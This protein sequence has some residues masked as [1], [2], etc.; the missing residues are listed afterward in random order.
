MGD[1]ISIH[2]G[3]FLEEL[4]RGHWRY[5]RVHE[6]SLGECADGDVPSTDVNCGDSG[7]LLERLR[8]APQSAAGADLLMFNCGLHD[9]KVAAGQTHRQV[10]AD[11]YAANIDSIVSIGT[12]LARQLVWVS[13]TPVV[14][15]LH[16]A[17]CEQFA[18]YDADVSAYNALAAA[19][20][21]R[22]GIP[23]IDLGAFSRSLVP[24]AVADHVHFTEAGQSA[25]AVF[26]DRALS[27]I[28][29]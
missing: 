5:E 29:G 16:Q 25:Q 9:V 26:L 14:D 20:C 18:R 8:T 1:S 13:T 4:V 28:T 17:R 6:P 22:R 12:Q 27:A 24:H 10:S 23:V 3:P 19:V 11:E 21:A 2:Y 15:H 7:M